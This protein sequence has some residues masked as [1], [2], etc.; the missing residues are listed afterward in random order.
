MPCFGSTRPVVFSRS[1]REESHRYPT[2]SGAGEWRGLFLH[3]INP[4]AASPGAHQALKTHPLINLVTPVKDPALRYPLSAT[5]YAIR[6]PT[7]ADGEKDD[8]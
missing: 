6:S 3:S 1:A 5:C 7:P 4:P 2:G 8:A